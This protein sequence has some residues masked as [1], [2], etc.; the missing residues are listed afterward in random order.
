[1]ELGRWNGNYFVVIHYSRCTCENCP[2]EEGQCCHD[3][4]KVAQRT[5]GRCITDD[6][7]FALA[8]LDVR[9]LNIAYEQLRFYEPTYLEPAARDQNK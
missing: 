8:C 6:E 9:L 5:V 2:Q 3:V 7:L 4:Q 1:M